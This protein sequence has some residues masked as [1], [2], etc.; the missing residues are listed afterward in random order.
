MP[1]LPLDLQFSPATVGQVAAVKY[2]AA[3]QVEEYQANRTA[4]DLYDPPQPPPPPIIQVEAV[5]RP[6]TAV[7][8]PR[9]AEPE[10]F[11]PD[12]ETLAAVARIKAAA[13][14]SPNTVFGAM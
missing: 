5:R 10:V 3:Q 9:A 13:R 1:S 7:K 14:A 8:P 2:W 12:A 4:E 11:S 6:A